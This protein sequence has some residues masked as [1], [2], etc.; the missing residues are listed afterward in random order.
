[1]AP[2]PLQFLSCDIVHYKIAGNNATFGVELSR[3]DISFVLCWSWQTCT[4]GPLQASK[5]HIV[6]ANCW[7]AQSVMNAY[8]AAN[9]YAEIHLS[10]KQFCSGHDARQ[11]PANP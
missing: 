2:N 7:I 1:M 3:Y 6:S 8:H 10:R 9:G 4:S 11:P 5:L